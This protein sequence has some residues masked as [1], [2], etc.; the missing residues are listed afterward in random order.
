MHD[1]SFKFEEFKQDVVAYAC[2]FSTW[3]VEPIAPR[4]QGQHQL[5][6]EF[7]AN[8]GYIKACLKNTTTHHT[9]TKQPP[10]KKTAKR[11]HQLK[12]F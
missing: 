2:N 11:N 6:S 12:Q 5:H 1:I 8:I 7:K 3:K 4:V 9:H 10:P